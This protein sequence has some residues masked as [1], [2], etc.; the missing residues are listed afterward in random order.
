VEFL[1]LRTKNG[2]WAMNRRMCSSRALSSFLSEPA[3]GVPT[4]DASYS[5]V[6]TWSVKRSRDT[7]LLQAGTTAGALPPPAAGIS[8][9][10]SAAPVLAHRPRNASFPTGLPLQEARP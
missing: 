5:A 10:V 3:E 8:S 4:T 7:G 1:V 6:R 2:E 9:S